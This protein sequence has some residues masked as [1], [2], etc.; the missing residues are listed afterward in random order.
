MSISSTATTA[1]WQTQ[2]KSH[3]RAFFRA[4]GPLSWITV[5]MLF[6][7]SKNFPKIIAFITLVCYTDY[8]RF[9]G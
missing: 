4:S 9:G 5:T 1:Q 2:E 7:L 8:I 6:I 3:I